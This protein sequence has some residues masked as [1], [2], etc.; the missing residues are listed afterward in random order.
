VYSGKGY[1]FTKKGDY[2]LKG[3][4]NLVPIFLC[5]WR[6]ELALTPLPEPGQQ[7]GAQ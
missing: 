3:F 5:E 2:E 6:T 7:V 1:S 4:D